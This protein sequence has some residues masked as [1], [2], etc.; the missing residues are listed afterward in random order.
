MALLSLTPPPPFLQ[1]PGEPTIT[2]DA[3]VRSFNTYLTAL[4]DKELADK[5]KRALLVHCIGVEAQRI[6]FT[7]ATGT[8]YDEACRALKS[9]FVPKVN[10]V[11]ERN[12]FRLRRQNV[13]S[14]S[15]LV[16]RD[17]ISVW[18]GSSVTLPYWVIPAHIAESLRL[19]NVSVEDEGECQC[20]ACSDYDRAGVFLNV[21]GMSPIWF[22]VVLI[23]LPA[24]AAAAAAADE[25]FSGLDPRDPISV[26]TGSSV[27]L[28]CWVLPPHNAESMQVHWFQRTPS[29]QISVLLY[30]ERQVQGS[31]QAP[32]FSGRAFLQ[33]GGLKRG[34]VSL[35]LEN[36]SVA[37]GGKF[38][39]YVSSDRHYNLT[40]VFLNVTV[41][42][43]ST[44]S[45]SP[46][47]NQSRQK[48]TVL[49]VLVVSLL[50]AIFI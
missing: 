27:T 45:S 36:V 24:A 33:P 23:L 7:L 22:L 8:T 38:Q 43:P 21:T 3:W 6:F 12:K 29:Y 19:E 49:F 9:F 13:E 1:T 28:P 32:Q 44:S 11:S 10:V 31:F 26:R 4:S 50:L 18:A 25:S 14:F 17:P 41:T 47:D 16:P 39:C 15:V 42:L 20:H 2:F 37:D 34:D 40:E 48:C 5:R 35:R 46:G 30:R